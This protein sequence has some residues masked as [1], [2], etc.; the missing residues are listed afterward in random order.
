MS[1]NSQ[2]ITK[3]KAVRRLRH[4]GFV[5]E[6]KDLDTWRDVNGNNWGWDGW[7]RGQFPHVIATI[8]QE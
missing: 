8:W 2:A 6:A 1:T 3:A 7:V 4:A 5:Q